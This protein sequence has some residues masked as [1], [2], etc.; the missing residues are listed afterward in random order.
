MII[1]EMNLQIEHRSGKR[2]VNA[3]ALS[4]NPKPQDSGEVSAHTEL[5]SPAQDGTAEEEANTEK[6]CNIGTLQR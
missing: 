4:R 6:Y 3:D 5:E 2:N 1:Q